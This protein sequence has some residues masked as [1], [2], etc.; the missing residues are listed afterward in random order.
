MST[1]ESTARWFR[2]LILVSWAAG[3][4]VLLLSVAYSVG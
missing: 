4:V 3:L 1:P 2:V